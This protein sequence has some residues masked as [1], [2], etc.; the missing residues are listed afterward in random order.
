MAETYDVLARFN[1]GIVAGDFDA[2]AAMPGTLGTE[3]LV[4]AQGAISAKN[5]VVTSFF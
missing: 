5:C 3:A 4:A 1:R 2:T